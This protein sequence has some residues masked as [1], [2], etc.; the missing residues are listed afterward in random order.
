MGTVYLAQQEEPI[1]REV[2]LKILH[3]NLPVHVDKFIEERQ[4]LSRLQHPHIAQ[5]L[6]AG[7]DQTG[8]P[9]FTMPVLRGSTITA[10][11]EEEK[12][13]L[14]DRIAL[15]SQVCE[16]V[17]Y[18]HQQRIIHRDLKP[19]NI[20]AQNINGKHTAK[21]ID[22]G[23][24]TSLFSEDS[25]RSSPF[26]GSLP[27][28][29]PEQLDREVD[30]DIRTDI[31]SLGVVLYT[32]L[33]GLPPFSVT[34][35]TT[36]SEYMAL[37]KS[38]PAIPAPIRVM[39]SAHAATMGLSQS[40][41]KQLLRGDI[42]A[43][44]LR[45]LAFD[46]KERYGSIETLQRDLE[47]FLEHRPT[48]VRRVPLWQRPLY[49]YR[50]NPWRAILVAGLLSLL[51]VGGVAYVNHKVL[52]AEK[53]A[54]RE[55]SNALE[56]ML[57]NNIQIISSYNMDLPPKE[58]KA[59]IERVE[60][61]LE[62]MG[63]GNLDDRSRMALL[64]G[65]VAFDL[66]FYEKAQHHFN[67]ILEE[68]KHI[69]D[70][71]LWVVLRAQD[72]LARYLFEVGDF[73]A[74]KR[75]FNEMRTRASQHFGET[76]RFV[77]R[78]DLGLA[79]IQLAQNQFAQAKDKFG[80]LIPQLE[81]NPVVSPIEIQS[82]RILQAITMRQLGE[83]DQAEDRL[84]QAIAL[85][86]KRVSPR[87]P[88]LLSAKY[89][90]ASIFVDR[91]A[92]LDEAYRLAFEVVSTRMAILERNDPKAL[93]AMDQMATVAI[94]LSCFR[95]A[96]YWLQKMIQVDPLLSA[97]KPN[98]PIRWNIRFM[99]TQQRIHGEPLDEIV[100]ELGLVIEDARAAGLWENP[101]YL[102]L[103]NNVADYYRQLNQLEKAL[104][105]SE[106]A[107]SMQRMLHEPQ[108]RSRLIAEVTMGEILQAM[109]RNDEAL[110]VY[111][112]TEPYLDRIPRFK[113]FVEEQ[114]AKLSA[115]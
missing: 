57:G 115:D 36:P 73:R 77:V 55:T 46:K 11:C 37:L 47:A 41:L 31:F 13:S 98:A 89:N 107:V 93:E 64:I 45:C 52:Q 21:I 29:S 2:A 59:F 92:N 20:I 43:I 96:E 58:A 75:E 60:R 14:H 112:L 110:K 42:N 103:V 38:Q 3:I 94:E 106:E 99:K 101:L 114:I 30:V 87:N 71:P 104:A 111:R 40:K 35:E 105:L 70:A 33:V 86:E 6:Q 51:P 79:M 109:E 102:T 44:L 32:L 12:L 49:L 22:F 27:Y 81:G 25:N 84:R 78:A 26:L 85:L 56:G 80:I 34:H 18:A 69:G 50:R 7:I 63:M 82:Y 54:F 4:T 100:A 53:E 15:F 76:N 95:E 108:F 68:Y 91:K 9:W 19:S 1:R 17:Q 62:R 90:L 65:L 83:L 10:Y 16:G 61:E 74:A 113:T 8:R 39:E 97:L 66:G 72:G 23:I 24:A 88:Y 67:S 48:S 5:V 28:I